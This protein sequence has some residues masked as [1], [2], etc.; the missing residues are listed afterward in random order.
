MILEDVILVSILGV[1]HG[2][3]PDH[4][5]TV[6]ML[7]NFQKILIFSISHGFGFV[8]FAIPLSFVLI[9]AKINPNILEIPSDILGLIIG[10]L[11]LF[12]AIVGKEFEIEP[13]G[14]GLLQGALV[15]TPSKILTVLLAITVGNFIDAIILVSVFVLTSTLSIL[16]LSLL[17][18]IPEKYSKIANI[19]VSLV[20]IIFF[21]SALFQLL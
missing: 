20:T 9:L 3:D 7:K 12:S 5:A 13:K 4:I 16:S 19:T 2:L 14:M 17:K 10:I 6:K 8:I 1:T 21:S 11:L 18:F 15:V